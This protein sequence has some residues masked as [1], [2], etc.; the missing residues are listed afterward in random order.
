M[1]EPQK[2]N[3]ENS[4]SGKPDLPEGLC[5]FERNTRGSDVVESIIIYYKNY[6]LMN[7]VFVERAGYYTTYVSYD[8][9]RGTGF[10]QEN[11][12]AHILTTILGV[13]MFR[14]SKEEIFE[15][16]IAKKHHM[17]DW[18]LFNQELWAK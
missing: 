2:I 4:L 14:V 12:R 5:K 11:S 7:F 1:M 10:F 18:L 13:D 9:A 6:G 3:I 15:I 17:S 8:Y 16:F